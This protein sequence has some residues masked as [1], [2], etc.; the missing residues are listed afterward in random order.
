[1]KEAGITP[2]KRKF[3]VEDHVDDCGS[4]LSGLG[5]DVLSMA[6]DLLIPSKTSEEAHYLNSTLVPIISQGLPVWWL[7]G[8]G[9]DK[10]GPQP[11]MIHRTGSLDELSSVLAELG[12]GVDV[13]ELCGGA[14]RASTI[15]LRRSEERWKL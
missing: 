10:P 6:V 14:G 7:K 8:S 13:T 2:S 5:S 9:T 12:P 15:C 11:P 3:K 1:M 4:D